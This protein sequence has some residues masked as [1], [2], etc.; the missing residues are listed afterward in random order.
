MGNVKLTHDFTLIPI[1]GE[2]AHDMAR[3]LSVLRG[4]VECIRDSLPGAEEGGALHALQGVIGEI[5]RI[6]MDLGVEG[7]G[8]LSISAQVLDAANDGKP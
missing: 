2:I 5:E 7:W 3:R 6:G 4:T 1:P 8:E